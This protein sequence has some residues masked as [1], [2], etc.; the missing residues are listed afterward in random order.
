MDFT[1]VAKE[2]LAIFI[3]RRK[4]VNFAAVAK[5]KTGP[6][7]SSKEKGEFITRRKKLNFEAVAKEK[8]V[9]CMAV[10]RKGFSSQEKSR[11]CI[12]KKSGFCSY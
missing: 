2:K 6:I 12:K 7:Y 10:R 9:M 5:G 1:A 3:A 4:K 8:P 11:F